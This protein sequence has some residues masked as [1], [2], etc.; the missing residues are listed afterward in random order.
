MVSMTLLSSAL[1]RQ[2]AVFL[3]FYPPAL[4]KYDEES[5]EKKE[6]KR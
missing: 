6:K 3:P 1:S 5:V 4:K 2:S